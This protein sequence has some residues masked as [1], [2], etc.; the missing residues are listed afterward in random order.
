MASK[1]VHVGINPLQFY[2][3]CD[4]TY[5]T[6]SAFLY[7][8][9]HIVTLDGHKYTFNGKG[10]YIL[11]ET[12]DNTFTLQGRMEEVSTVNDTLA[13]ASVFTAIAVGQKDSSTVEFRLEDDLYLVIDGV[14]ERLEDFDKKPYTNVVVMREANKSFSATFF[15]TGAFIEVRAADSGDRPGYISTV[16]VSLPSNF[17]G[18]TRGLMGNY[19]GDTSD[20]LIP[21][22]RGGDPLPVN[23]SLE[24]LH[25]DFGIT[26]EL[27]A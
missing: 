18:Q 26:C 4:C 23:A 8:D 9:P 13:R 20:D 14:E 1:L 5:L 2:N 7:G 15:S 19:N 3:V 12:E 11:I 25:W 16:I 21:R 10:E 6:P 24:T 22:S 17:K 27:V